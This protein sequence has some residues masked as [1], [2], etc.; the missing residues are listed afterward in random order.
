LE[1]LEEGKVSSVQVVALE[2][3][4]LSQ[5]EGYRNSGE[6]KITRQTIKAAIE[7][8]ISPRVLLIADY[9]NDIKGFRYELFCRARAAGTNVVTVWCDATLEECRARNGRRSDSTRYPDSVYDCVR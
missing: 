2:S 6:E 1:R 9:L 7:R 4:K 3:V 5:E 8:A